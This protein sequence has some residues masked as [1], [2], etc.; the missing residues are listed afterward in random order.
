[1]PARNVVAS[2]AVG[3]ILFALARAIAILVPLGYTL[4]RWAAA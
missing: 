1:M 4:S 3:P 2:A